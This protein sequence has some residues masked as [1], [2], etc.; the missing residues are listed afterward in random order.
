MLQAPTS[1]SKQQ[2]DQTRTP[3]RPEQERELHPR[4]GVSAMPAWAAAAGRRSPHLGGVRTSR[5]WFWLQTLHG[6]Q[7]VLRFLER[8]RRLKRPLGFR[9]SGAVLQR[10]CSCGGTCPTC[11]DEREK[12]LHGVQAKLLVS[13]PGDPFEVEA[14]RIADQVIGRGK[15]D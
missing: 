12:A 11:Q 8:S 5:G 13:T 9:P 15:P 6:N 7:A 3:E 2:S 4:L 1:E 10:K 14:D